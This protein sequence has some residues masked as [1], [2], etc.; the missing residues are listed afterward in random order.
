MGKTYVTLHN[1]STAF[2]GMPQARLIKLEGFYKTRGQM[3]PEAREEGKD[4]K[5]KV[6]KPRNKKGRKWR[7]GVLAAGGDVAN[8]WVVWALQY[9]A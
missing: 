2:L 9:R 3:T 4:V 1:S 5:W 8:I 6:G 7:E